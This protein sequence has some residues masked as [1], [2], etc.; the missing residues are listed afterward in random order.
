MNPLLEQFLTEGRSLLE[1]ASLAL[2]ALEAAPADKDHL[3]A[4]FRAVHTIKGASGLFEI[5]P[6][7]KAVHA[8]EDLL[9]AVREGDVPFTPDLADM[10]LMLLDQV[11]DWLDQLEAHQELAD[12]ADA[13]A[14]R[15]AAKLR[16][17]LTEDSD[18]RT[19][20]PGGAAPPPAT[21]V[22]PDDMATEDKQRCAGEPECW[23]IDYT[24]DANA[25]YSG[26]DPL[27]TVMNTPGLRWVGT[28]APE[29]WPEPGQMDPFEARLGFA[30]VACAD[31]VALRAH[32][33]YVEDQ[34]QLTRLSTD[35]TAR[36]EIDGDTLAL[37]RDLIGSQRRLLA[38][39]GAEQTTPARIAAARRMLITIAR[40]CDTGALQDIRASLIGLD[41][42]APEAETRLDGLAEAL[43][44]QL[45]Q[46]AAPDEPQP[47]L[48]P[49]LGPVEP[50][51]E[52]RKAISIR[53]DA[54]RIDMLMNLAGELIVAKNALP[55]LARRAEQG[56]PSKTLA[57][58]I[59]S[60]HDVINRI[61]DELQTAVMKV[62]MVPVGTVFGRFNRLVRDLSRKLDKRI[63]LVVEGEDTEAD[64]SVVEELADPM[65]HLIRNAVDHGLETVADRRASGKSDEGTIRLKAYQQDD[66]VI[67]EVSD[68]GRGIDLDR[69]RAKALEKGLVDADTLSAMADATA[70]QLVMA[71][72]LSTKEQISDLSGRGVGMDVVASMVRRIGG[73][74]S[75][76]STAGQG[77]TVRIALPLSMAVQR[78][79]MIEVDGGYYGVSVDAVVESQRLPRDRIHRHRDNETV[80]LR[81]R[82]IPLLHLR[83]LFGCPPDTSKRDI[84]L[85]VVEVDGNEVGLVV[86]R[87][88]AGVDA[89]VKPMEGLLR[90]SECF[91]GTALLGD[92]SVL[93][94]LNLAE[95]IR[96]RWT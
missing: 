45:A 77:T 80:L 55:F 37:A 58:E 93:L 21:G 43:G 71:P 56:V 91:S 14:D 29:V 18:T 11:S 9:D 61:A 68:D 94:A 74:I 4:L 62:R 15:L 65:V 17:P 88:H 59:K 57:R 89:I 19:D 20:T 7:T 54:D 60:Q 67:I 49:D 16:Q 78:L 76:N 87:F 3:A 12:G 84:N 95:V 46:P 81:Q 85:M 51:T 64:K 70:L 72:G 40:R 13:S 1:E 52:S 82:M 42:E 79:M 36:S 50:K 44:T 22:W 6:F 69:V 35:A 86:D 26:D 83:D 39:Q 31:E 66:S 23:R 38:A 53:V 27:L 41:P 73:T 25:F 96:C 90:H 33:L 47:D 28:V 8:G 2:L 92:G 34:V 5:A 48:E 75:L 30:A 32:F 10:L 63:R 24:P